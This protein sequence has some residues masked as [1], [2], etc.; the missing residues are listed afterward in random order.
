MLKSNAI[1]T[2]RICGNKSKK[3]T[4][5]EKRVLMSV[6]WNKCEFSKALRPKR[7]NVLIIS[8]IRHYFWI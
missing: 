2:S 7:G 1:I 4:F 8:C 5:T 6:F 3:A